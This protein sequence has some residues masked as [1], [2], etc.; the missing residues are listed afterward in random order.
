MLKKISLSLLLMLTGCSGYDPDEYVDPAFTPF[1]K[2]Y[3]KDKGLYTG[4]GSIRRI[5]IRFGNLTTLA[6]VCRVKSVKEFFVKRKY[7]NIT[8]DK[9]IW[10]KIDDATR[11]LLF[12]HEMGHCDLSLLHTTDKSIMNSFLMPV[13]LFNNDPDYYLN[14]LFKEGK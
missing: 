10:D 12:Y 13:S 11:L 6:G 7:Y 2:Q 14:Q 3:V 5:G 9:T 8:I 1:I 4:I